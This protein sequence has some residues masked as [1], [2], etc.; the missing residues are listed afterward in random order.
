[1]S[2]I[3]VTSANELSSDLKRKIEKTFSE[4]HSDSVVFLYE[5]D[6]SLIGGILVKD[7][8]RYYDASVRGRLAVVRRN[9][10]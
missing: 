9:L 5:I 3:Y 10:R 6:P 4:K 2:E 7:G 1:M 8:D